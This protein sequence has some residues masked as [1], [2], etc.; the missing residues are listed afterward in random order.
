MSTQ[1]L[2]LDADKDTAP[3]DPEGPPPFS[4]PVTI[5]EPQ[6]GWLS[7]NLGEL[8]RYRDLLFL[9]VRRDFTAQYRQSV[10]GIGWA[11]LNP[12]FLVVLNTIV[13]SKMAD[14]PSDG[15]P[16]PVFNFCAVIAW[17]YFAG[18]LTGSSQSV[19]ASAHLVSKVYFPRLILPLKRVVSGL[20]T[21]SI[22]FSLLLVLM[23][24]YGIAPTWAIVTLPAFMILS[25]ATG[26]SVG[27]WITAIDVK[28]RDIRRLVSPMTRFWMFATPVVYSISMV[29]EKWRTVYSLNPMVSVIEG[30]RWAMLG[31]AAPDW[32]MMGVSAS[33]T[34]IL[35]VGGLYFFRRVEGTFADVI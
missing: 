29:P 11:F 21:F 8:W 30:F 24:W 9:L 15:I 31:K 35:L 19:A 23:A 18:C 34:A 1:N 12:V 2:T 7:L 16:F 28:Y 14:F 25:A 27:L 26:L 5:I 22:R 13:F 32:T 20:I 17:E 4:G 3:H 6:R 33:V 10:L